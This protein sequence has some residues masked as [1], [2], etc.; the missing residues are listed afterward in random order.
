MAEVV[1][2]NRFSVSQRRGSRVSDSNSTKVEFVSVCRHS[3][4]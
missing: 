4:F 3:H 1:V 2:S